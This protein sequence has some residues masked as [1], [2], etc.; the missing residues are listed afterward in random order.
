LFFSSCVLEEFR[1]A[2]EPP[3]VREV[4]RSPGRIC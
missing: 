1:K 2:W 4:G 3:R